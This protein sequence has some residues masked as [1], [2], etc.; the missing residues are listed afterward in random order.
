MFDSVRRPPDI[1]YQ[2]KA[3]EYKHKGDGPHRVKIE[4]YLLVSHNTPSSTDGPFFSPKTGNQCFEQA[5][6]LPR[7]TL[8]E[9]SPLPK[10]GTHGHRNEP[11]SHSSSYLLFSH[12]LEPM[13]S[14][15]NNNEI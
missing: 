4:R 12:H 2:K 10:G 15:K 6:T 8:M 7:Q 5:G 14:P 9:P 1:R 11:S 3:H 13:L